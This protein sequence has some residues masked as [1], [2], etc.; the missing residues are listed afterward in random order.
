M[1]SKLD[2]PRQRM[3]ELLTR[4]LEDQDALTAL[5]A[6]RDLRLLLYEWEGVLAR[7]GVADGSSWEEVGS[8]LG[9][10]RQAAWTRYKDPTPETPAIR[11]ARERVA[12][13][14]N[15]SSE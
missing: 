8:L 3:R 2:K 5:A 14:R 10:S 9:V 11:E 1:T 12:K 7:K 4:T 13:A 15:R 6:A